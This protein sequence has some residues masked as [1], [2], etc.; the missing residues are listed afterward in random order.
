MIEDARTHAAN[1]SAARPCRR[2]LPVLLSVLKR[3]RRLRRL[4]VLTILSAASVL[5]ALYT[6]RPSDAPDPIRPRTIEPFSLVDTLGGT[7]EPADWRD[8]KAVVLF[9]IGSDCPASKAYVAEMGGLA[10]KYHEEGLLFFGI[11][12]DPRISP[13]LTPRHVEDLGLSFPIL[14]DTA[15]ELTAS[16]GL[17][18]TPGCALLDSQGHVLYHG[19]IDDRIASDGTIRDTPSK[20]DL[21]EAILAVLSS[22][23]PPFEHADSPVRPWQ[24]PS[25]L[26]AGE[27][28]TFNTHVAP[29]LWKRCA[30][31]HRPGEVG[32]FSLL[33]YRDASKR[34]R[35]LLESM[36][37]REMPPWRVIHGYGDFHDISPLSARELAIFSHWVETGAQEGEARD[38]REP[39]R[40]TDG[41]QLGTPDVVVRMPKPFTVPAGDTDIYRAFVLPLPLNGDT[42]VATIEFRPGNRRVVHHAR[43]YLDDTGECRRRDRADE[44]ADDGFRSTGNGDIVRPGLGGWIP[45]LIPRMP[46]SDVG[47]V[48][49]RG[50]D[51]VVLIHYH[52]TGKDEADQS[53]V[54]L[55]LCKKPPKRKVTTLSLSTDQIDIPP[56]ARRH[57]IALTTYMKADAHAV[58]VFPHGHYLLREISLTATLPGGRVVPMLWIQDWNYDWQGQ[59][60]FARAVPLSKGTRLDVVAYYDNSTENPVNPHRPPQRVQFGPTSL[61]EM[62]GC[63]L[64][65]IADDPE[66]QRIFDRTFSFGL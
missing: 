36:T 31:C 38:R 37:S 42:A 22:R 51:L 34:S 28:V 10:K 49:T 33:E 8:A 23:P 59:Y 45:G 26:L 52:G 12:H 35:F 43:F 19:R 18:G 17:S 62:L 24:K 57:R 48:V 16:L 25:A 14:L 54:G 44:S 40:F 41:W 9:V 21:E 50:S 27:A 29:I 56:G 6:R 15:H 1:L 66:S 2:F 20:R 65:V 11:R 58:S 7:H 46:P 32:P 53:S 47:T 13:G 39:A 30:G 60:H 61:D 5:S 55:F 4:F 63:H 64:Q 3:R